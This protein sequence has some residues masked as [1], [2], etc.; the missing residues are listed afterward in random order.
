MITDMMTARLKPAQPGRTT[1]ISVLDIGSTKICCLIAKLTPRE[2]SDV[3]AGRSHAVEVLGYGY[4]RSR[5]I[6]S[7]VIVDMDA[8]E[9]AI[10]LAVD[11]AERMAGVTVESVIA[12]VSCGR[13]QSEIFSA[14]VPAR[15]SQDR[16]RKPLR[17]LIRSALFSS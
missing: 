17:L 8:A 13:L 15:V 10:R 6:K 1:L 11:A 4:Q 3:L 12:N 5:G 7:G 14:T 2:G 9:Q 16:S